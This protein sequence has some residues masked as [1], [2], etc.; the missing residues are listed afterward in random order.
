MHVLRAVFAAHSPHLHS[1]NRVCCSSSPSAAKTIF[2]V[3]MQP[4][5]GKQFANKRK[6]CPKGE[7]V[8]SVKQEHDEDEGEEEEVLCDIEDPDAYWRDMHD[9]LKVKIAECRRG[10]VVQCTLFGQF[11]F[12]VGKRPKDW[13]LKPLPKSHAALRMKECTQIRSIAELGRVLLPRM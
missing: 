12:H 9:T 4:R 8:V 5:P 7:E 13:Y 11:S 2:A 3:A 1:G 10:Q 6:R